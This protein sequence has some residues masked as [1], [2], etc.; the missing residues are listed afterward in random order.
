MTNV[1]ILERAQAEIIERGQNPY[2]PVEQHLRDLDLIA[3]LTELKIK[4]K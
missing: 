1:E 4:F 3:A 2:Y